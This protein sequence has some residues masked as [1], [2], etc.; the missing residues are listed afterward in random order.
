MQSVAQPILIPYQINNKIG[1]SDTNGNL[2]IAAVYDDIPVE[3]NK[4]DIFIGNNITESKL[5]HYEDGYK[6]TATKNIYSV[7]YK[8]KV[9]LATNLAN[10]FY[11]NPNKFCIAESRER[12]FEV[13]RFGIFTDSSIQLKYTSQ[14]QI[15]YF[16]N[17]T[18]CDLLFDKNGKL[19][20]VEP[21]R[22]IREMY[23][24]SSYKKIDD[25]NFVLF[26]LKDFD[27]NLSLQ[28]YNVT[29]G[30]FDKIL[31]SGKDRIEQ[32][33]GDDSVK[34][35]DNNAAYHVFSQNKKQYK[36]KD[37]Y[38]IFHNKNGFSIQLMDEKAK[39]KSRENETN[40][41]PA[42]TKINH[43]EDSP[44]F[45]H[46]EASRNNA[47]LLYPQ[48][49]YDNNTKKVGK[50]IFSSL[51][52]TD[53][54]YYNLPQNTD[55]F[56]LIE[57]KFKYLVGE[58]HPAN[59]SIVLFRNKNKWGAFISYNVTSTKMFDSIF[60]LNFE[61][62][63]KIKFL[64]FQQNKQGITESTIVDENMEPTSN[65]WYDSVVIRKA[66]NYNTPF[67]INVE[68]NIALLY[69]NGS[70]H[71]CAWGDSI[72]T[73]KPL[74]NIEYN[75]KYFY[76]YKNDKNNYG[77]ISDYNYSSIITEA[78]FPYKPVTIFY[79]YQNEMGLHLIQLQNETNNT[80]VYALPSGKLFFKQ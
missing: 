35:S 33:Y 80:K 12:F 43:V 18:H 69:K 71:F 34:V 54:F 38:K 22:S 11:F 68:N 41:Q 44:I 36:I 52:K 30:K 32:F 6:T 28:Q 76:T 4:K 21:L 70:A 47:N 37:Y 49:F 10:K 16:S 5:I 66:R 29:A 8:G 72:L 57:N 19:V 63:K 73:Q 24:S 74:Q 67:Q 3:Y 7:I 40:Y 56:V 14:E 53:T 45:R 64:V 58:K 50:V 23:F 13:N 65:Q 9:Q 20:L 75:Y 79:N 31:I 42:R 60:V 59:S 46:V 39:Q 2:V 62:N 26:L 25:S 55:S 77:L 15:K 17:K 48:I 51:E 27:D 1:L 78:F 61:R